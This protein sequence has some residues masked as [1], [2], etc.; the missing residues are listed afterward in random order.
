VYAQSKWSAAIQAERMLEFYAKIAAGKY[1]LQANIH[2]ARRA[3]I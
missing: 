3:G 2:A 1:A